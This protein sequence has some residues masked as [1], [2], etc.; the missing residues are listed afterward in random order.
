[1]NVFAMPLGSRDRGSSRLRCYRVMDFMEGDVKFVFA[2]KVISTCD[3]V[4][5]QKRCDDF[6]LSLSN[7]CKSCKM[8]MVYDL[9]DDFSLY[10][11][12]MPMAQQ[13]TVVTVDTPERAERVRSVRNGPVVVIP[14]GVDYLSAPVS[15]RTHHGSI[16]RIFTF[17]DRHSVISG[18]DWMR[19]FWGQYDV[20]YVSDREYSHAARFVEWSEAGFIWDALKNDVCVL[21]HETGSAARKGNNRLMTMMALGIPTAV[22]SCT[23]SYVSLLERAGHEWLVYDTHEQLCGI[24]EKLEDPGLRTEVSKALSEQVWSF[25]HPAETSKKFAE[26]FTG[27]A[28]KRP[29][30]SRIHTLLREVK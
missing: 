4:F 24:M 2:W 28:E 26:L 12:S 14:S 10:H 30:G 7:A 6:A 27:L 1:M 16:Q 3:V 8:P 21:S 20:S 11:G 19:P 17:G 23:P 22:R 25:A 5:I 13:A 15:P 9:D 29:P 18:L